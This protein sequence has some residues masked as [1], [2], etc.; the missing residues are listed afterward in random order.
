MTVVEKVEA[1]Q[2]NDIKQRLKDR[3]KENRQT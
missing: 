2:S 3:K 1:N